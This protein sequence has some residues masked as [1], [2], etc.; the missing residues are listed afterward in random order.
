VSDES[1]TYTSGIDRSPQT[2]FRERE[3]PH[4]HERHEVQVVTEPGHE[5][6]VYCPRT[7][8]AG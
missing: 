6:V 8:V 4:C 7:G 2:E 5:R 3:C 1:G